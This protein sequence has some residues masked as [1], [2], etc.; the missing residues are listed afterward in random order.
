M[1]PD[2]KLLTVWLE[3]YANSICILGEQ[4]LAEENYIKISS[5]YSQSGYL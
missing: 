3:A 5:H 4:K 1:D 2:L